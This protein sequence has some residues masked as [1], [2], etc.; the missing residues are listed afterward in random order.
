MISAALLL[1]SSLGLALSECKQWRSF[2]SASHLILSYYKPI[3]HVVCTGALGRFKLKLQKS[4]ITIAHSLLMCAQHVDSTNPDRSN[5]INV[6][7]SH[8]SRI[9][10]VETAYYL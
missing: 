6:F 1:Y 10:D 2:G 5:K 4:T 7:R 9:W 8:R 3:Q